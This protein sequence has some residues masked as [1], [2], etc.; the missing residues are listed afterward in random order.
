MNPARLYE[1]ERKRHSI[2]FM[3]LLLGTKIISIGINRNTL[4]DLTLFKK[5]QFNSFYHLADF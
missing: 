4:T 3:G 2:K 5:H 1:A